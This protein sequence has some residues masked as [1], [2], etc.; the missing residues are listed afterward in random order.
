M[1]LIMASGQGWMSQF[2]PGI[3]Y[4]EY[5]DWIVR[6]LYWIRYVDWMITSPLILLALTVLAGLPGI[7]ILSVII[8]DVTMIVLVCTLVLKNVNDRSILL[9]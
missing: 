4:I 1:Y 2:Y 6:Q 9:R 5:V 8:A 7:E 3:V